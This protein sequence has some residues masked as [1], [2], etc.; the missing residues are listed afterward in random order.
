MSL[1][2]FL[3]G[4]FVFLQSSVLLGWFS[5]DSKLLGFVGLAFV[6]VLVIEAL[7]GPVTLWKR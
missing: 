6:A 3:L 5:V 4:L 7:R 2:T 1:S